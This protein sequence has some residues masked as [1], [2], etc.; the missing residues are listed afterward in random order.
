[1][2]G[3]QL[4]AFAQQHG[5]G[6][7]A[8]QLAHVAGEGVAGQ[9]VQRRL[10]PAIVIALQEASGFGGEVPGQLQDVLGA[11][12][13]RRQ[14]DGEVRQAIEQ[15]LAEAPFLDQR[16][17][18]AVG[19]G[20][21]AHVDLVRLRAAQRAH[22]AFLQHAQQLGL[23][24]QRHVADLV[25]EQGAAVGCIE[26]AL[27][28]AVGAGEGALAVAEQLALQQVLRQR[29]AVLHDER[30]AAAEAAV[31][32]GAGD[33]FLAGAG[34]AGQQHA[35]GVVQHLAD[36]LVHAAHGRAATDQAVV[37]AQRRAGRFR[38][39]RLGGAQ[40]LQQLVLGQGEGA[41]AGQRGGEDVE[42]AG[43]AAGHQQQAV[44][45]RLLVLQRQAQQAAPGLV[46]GRQEAGLVQAGVEVGQAQAPVL[47][48][49]VLQQLLAV[50]VA[51]HA[52]FVLGG[53]AVQPLGGQGQARVGTVQQVQL[54]Q[55]AAG[56][57][58]G[59]LGQG[60]RQLRG[61]GQAGQLGELLQQL[62]GI[63]QRLADV[64][65]QRHFLKRAFRQ[66]HR[67]VL[68]HRPGWRVRG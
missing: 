22:L 21:D 58:R 8:F 33:Q 68:L 44:D 2:L 13:Q 52:G 31:M 40:A 51:G 54:G 7:Q 17:Q 48:Q 3:Q 66:I 14:L 20:D 6:D 1:M 47:A 56:Q 25:E 34:L 39:H 23:Q 9:V 5:A 30:L 42:V 37:A 50:V 35:G 63:G 46:D 18:V 28:V 24:R 65:Q 49:A 59:C 32:D 4:A 26:Q 53:L 15:V 38:R 67:P 61:A 43:A 36:Q 62:F 29:G 11:G 55:A 64:P 57:L 19:G 27:A 10:G 16:A 12:A 41:Q 45:A 60:H